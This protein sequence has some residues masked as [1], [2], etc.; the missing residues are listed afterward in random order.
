M[1]D[2]LEYSVARFRRAENKGKSL[3]RR[4]DRECRYETILGCLQ[5]LYDVQ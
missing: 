5:E 2:M 4:Y 1:Y 3:T